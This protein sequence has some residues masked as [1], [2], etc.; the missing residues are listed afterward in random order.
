MTAN[1]IQKVLVVSFSVVPAADRQGVEIE[2]VLKALAARFQVDVLTIRTA[3][4]G[5]VERYRRTRMLRVP[6]GTGPRQEQVEAFRRAVK[7]QLEGTEYD[8]I[9]FRS[10]YG[11]VPICQLKEH[12]DCKLVFEVALNSSTEA[13]RVGQQAQ[14]ERN[15]QQQ[16]QQCGGKPDHGTFGSVESVGTGTSPRMSSTTSIAVTLRSRLS[17]RTMR[18]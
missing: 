14:V 1:P 11:G 7:R 8:L 2:T 16:Q 17:G 4:M 15:R 3:D 9:H 5:Y 13:G 12:L 6:V 18:R 10:A